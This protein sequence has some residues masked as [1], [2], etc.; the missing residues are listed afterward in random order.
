MTTPAELYAPI[1]PRAARWVSWALLAA[2]VV[3][4]V[5]LIVVM[6]AGDLGMTP[7]DTVG[8]LA[9]GSLIAWFCY[10]QATV[11]AL[12]DTSGLTVRNLIVVRRLAWAEIITV[13]YGDGR[14]WAQLDLS[15]GDTLAVMGIQRADGDFAQGEARRLATLVAI[16]E[17]RRHD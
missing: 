12:P 16:H 17:A 3:A 14:S 2:T 15:D 1:R 11:A 13:R 4:T 5:G 10:R 8:T 9:V 6:Y 7:G